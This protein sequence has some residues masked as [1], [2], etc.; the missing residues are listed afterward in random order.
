MCIAIYDS[1]INH[2]C[3][4]TLSTCFSDI[5]ISVKSQ[6]NLS[7]IISYSINRCFLKFENILHTQILCLFDIQ[8]V[9]RFHARMKFDGS[10]S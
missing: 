5:S 4:R 10:W 9:N 8:F 6:Y 7:N 3:M 1:K 2:G